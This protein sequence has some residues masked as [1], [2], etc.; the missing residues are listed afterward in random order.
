[1]LTEAN[2]PRRQAPWDWN[3]NAKPRKCADCGEEFMPRSRNAKYCPEC[4]EERK[5]MWDRK[6]K[7]R[8]ERR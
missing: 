6:S 5:G 7:G 2:R 4:R 3:A 1:M 8:K